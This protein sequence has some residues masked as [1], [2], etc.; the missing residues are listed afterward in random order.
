MDRREDFE[1]GFRIGEKNER[2]LGLV[3][4]FIFAACMILAGLIIAVADPAGA[5]AAL[6]F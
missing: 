1:E 2:S 5:L 4:L 6:G 3:M